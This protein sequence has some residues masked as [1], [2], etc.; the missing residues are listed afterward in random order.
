[1]DKTPSYTTD[2]QEIIAT[3]SLRHNVGLKGEA[4]PIAVLERTVSIP[5]LR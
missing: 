5:G 2:C 4:D 1:M 3:K